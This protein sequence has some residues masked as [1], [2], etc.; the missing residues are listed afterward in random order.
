MISE[1]SNG[2]SVANLAR[3]QQEL[4]SS[5]TK[6]R[7]Q[8]LQE[9]R[10]SL[11]TQGTTVQSPFSSSLQLTRWV[12]AELPAEAQHVLVQYLLATYP[13]Y[14]DRPSRRAVQRCITTL[15]SE[16]LVTDFVPIFLSFIQTEAVKS[17]IASSSTFVL[18]EWCSIVLKQISGNADLWAKY[19]VSIASAAAVVLERCLA[20]PS[21]PSRRQ[22]AI[23]VTRFGLKSTLANEEIAETATQRLLTHLTAKSGRP[24]AYNAPYIGI[25]AA[26]A[27]ASKSAQAQV[28]VATPDICAFYVREIV[29]SKTPVPAHIAKGLSSFFRCYVDEAV[30][31]TQLAPAIEKALLRAPEV[32]LQGVMLPLISSLPTNIDLSTALAQHLQKSLIANVKSSNAS[33]RTS[34]IA[35]FEAIAETSHDQ[36]QVLTVCK[37]LNKNIKDNKAAEQ[38]AAYLRMLGCMR[39]DA[40]NASENA[41]SLI[42][43]ATKETS[44]QALEQMTKTITKLCTTVVRAGSALPE[45]LIKAVNQGLKDK[46]TPTKRSWALCYTELQGELSRTNGSGT[47][48]S[49]KLANDVEGNMLLVFKE[50]ATNPI[51]AAQS[52]LFATACAV[53][54]LV[55]DERT[56]LAHASWRKK[57]DVDSCLESTEGK[58]SFLLNHKAYTKLTD[59]TDLTW[60]LRALM[61]LVS[62][63]N[64]SGSNTGK[65]WSQA[66]IFA[67]SAPSVPPSARLNCRAGLHERYLRYPEIVA[68]HIIRGVWLW[69]QSAMR[70]SKDT[71]ATS[72]TVDVGSLHLVV[73]AICPKQSEIL[74]SS[75]HISSATLQTQF[76]QML[77]LCR[78][79]LVRRISWIEQC[80]QSGLDPGALISENVQRCFDNIQNLTSVGD[81]PFSTC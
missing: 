51:A 26:A 33:M 73:K 79:T 29:G 9:C 24:T 13:F 55:L 21:K 1:L 68:P 32:I 78:P 62:S 65:D 57:F 6:R 59:T 70:Q 5:S 11:E 34:A 30:F 39:L 71:P 2:H 63:V 4:F 17:S 47:S 35:A 69:V 28:T 22:T 48:Q 49:Q 42:A 31:N 81:R 50:V 74:S 20:Y 38:R 43:V 53:V 27:T 7:I 25:I 37:E 12:A 44:D 64:E 19:G 46:K 56:A 54:A 16:L 41:T 60:L 75:G 52:G 72:T 10:D 76:L 14:V 3:V 61:A 58:P 8:E 80:L 36:S 18:L 40:D 23:S 67:A 66:V 15:C 45:S 77:V